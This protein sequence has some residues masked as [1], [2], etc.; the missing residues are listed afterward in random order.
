VNP[1]Y[2]RVIGAS[3]TDRRD[4]FALAARRLG[5][6]EQNVEKDFWVCWTLDVLFHW[7]PSGGPPL[8]FKG[9]T[10]W[11]K[12]FG[13]IQRFSEDID[14]TVF[15]DDLGEG[16]SI[17]RLEALTGKK[18][19]VRL[20][21][22]RDACRSY[23]SGELR[24][25][26]RGLAGQ[27]LESAEVGPD[28]ITIELDDA[29]P[30]GQTL[31]IRYPSVVASAAPYVHPSVRIECGAKSALDPN[32]PAEVEPYVAV[33]LDDDAL[34]HPQGRHDPLLWILITGHRS[35]PSTSPP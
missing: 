14:I 30:D 32:V 12:A 15:R 26:L 2:T 11:S 9:G 24:S 13:L 18:R 25:Q 23:I 22:I 1:A 8:L 35:I 31:L 5:T 28:A 10:S 6:A 21:G 7:L 19:K 4:L 3:D 29:D 34:S 20:D 16:A 17:D 33:E 27:A